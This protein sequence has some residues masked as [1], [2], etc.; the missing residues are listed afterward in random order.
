MYAMIL[1]V[2]MSQSGGCS[3]FVCL[4]HWERVRSRSTDSIRLLV[5]LLHIPNPFERKN[6]KVWFK[7]VSTSH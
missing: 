4:Y 6:V 5:P 1:L 7:G 3:S 2:R